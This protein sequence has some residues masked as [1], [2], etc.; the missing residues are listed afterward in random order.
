MAKVIGLGGVFFRCR[1]VEATRAWYQRVLGIH[2]D[3]YGGTSFGHAESAARFPEGARTIWAPFKADSDY[4]KPSE[5]DYMLNL[6]VDDF[7]G[8]LGQLKAE[9]VALEGEPMIESYGKFAWVMDPDGRKIEL[10]Q[11]VEPSS[12]V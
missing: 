7:D 6:M 11:P 2:I 8:M 9:G 12:A 10:W 5:A 1:D 4:F 3:D